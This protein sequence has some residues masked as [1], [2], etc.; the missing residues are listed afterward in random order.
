MGV[1]IFISI[2][3][4]GRFWSRTSNHTSIIYNRGGS[5]GGSELHVARFKTSY[6]VAMNT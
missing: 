6:V 2:G 1:C 4:L 3:K 5:A